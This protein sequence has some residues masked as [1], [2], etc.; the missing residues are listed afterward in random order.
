M[1]DMKLTG[2]SHR[3]TSIKYRVDG[4]IDFHDPAKPSTTSCPFLP[5]QIVNVLDVP[6]LAVA[7][8]DINRR[9]SNLLESAVYTMNPQDRYLKPRPAKR[10]QAIPP[11]TC[12]STARAATGKNRFKLFGASSRDTPLPMPKANEASPM[13]SSWK[14]WKRRPE[15]SPSPA[16]SSLLAKFQRHRVIQPEALARN[17]DFS[18]QVKTSKE[19]STALSIPRCVPNYKAASTNDL[20]RV[21]GLALQRPGF[22][23]G[24]GLVTKAHPGSKS[25]FLDVGATSASKEPRHQFRGSYHGHASVTLEDLRQ[26]ILAEAS[27]SCDLGPLEP[28][29]IRNSFANE[30]YAGVQSMS[31]KGAMASSSSLL[32]GPPTLSGLEN[33]SKHDD[34]LVSLEDEKTEGDRSLDHHGPQRKRSFPGS[35]SSSYCTS[36]N[37]SPGLT[38]TNN[39]SDAI[40]HHRLS[41]PETPSA[42]EY[43][44]DLIEASTTILASQMPRIQVRDDEAEISG[45]S[46]IGSSSVVALHDQT[47]HGFVGY[48]LPE[49]DQGS[50]S[51]LK[52]PPNNS[53]N[54]SKHD[55]VHSWNDGSKHRM[56]ALETLITD[57]GYLGKAIN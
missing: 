49:P 13:A 4:D 40:S 37:F 20:S 24:P 50:T 25:S 38:S 17:Q 46:G 7:M 36:E 47:F 8:N 2:L 43:G 55:Q 22:K 48:N 11:L 42:S 32:S 51:T 54:S 10:R 16:R 39:L 27:S 19:V 26:D 35:V 15:A 21:D 57:L 1:Y 6:T 9:E 3:L 23:R 52:R 41:Q 12:P 28:P 56:T 30:G 44:G 45:L 34:G 14:F 29:R 33:N 18:R 5:G 31:S 53:F